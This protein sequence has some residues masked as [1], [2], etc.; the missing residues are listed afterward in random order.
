MTSERNVLDYAYVV[1]KW[2]RM[3]ILSVLV[4]GVA[5]VGIS[6]LLPKEWTADTTLLPPEQDGAQLGLAS[7]L[8]SKAPP[9]LGMFLGQSD[10][11][12]RL[13]TIL[14][15]RRVL[16][17]VVDQ[18]DLV[19]EFGAPNRAIAIEYLDER[20]RR[21][22]DEDG[23]LHIQ[24]TALH[25][26][27]AADLANAL[28]G[29]LDAV[30]RHYKSMQAQ[31]LR[32]FLEDR[33]RVVREEL[34]HAGE[35]LRVFQQTHGVV[36]MQ[37]QTAASVEVITAVA[38]ELALRQVE[39]DMQ[40]HLL[41]PGHEQ[42]ERAELQVAALRR[43]VRRLV[44]EA[45][46]VVAD[47]P[48]APGIGTGPMLMELPAL[49]QQYARLVLELEVKEAVVGYLGTRL[50]EMR[51]KEA[52]NTPTILVLDP[53]VPPAFRS[54]PH[55]KAIVAGAAGVSLVVSVL[56]AFGLESLSRIRTENAGRIAAI[57][58]LLAR[59]DARD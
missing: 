19:R 32:E 31:M 54:A 38:Q 18:L 9:N 34:D 5:A 28:A 40:E 29:E 41:G 3:I 11:S 59:S 33:I 27:L 24:V 43:Q 14:G 6:F 16:G 17:A 50:E 26:Q 2:R 21:E 57:R 25:P 42:L 4:V 23:G 52:K 51:Y 8:S 47:S 30:N 53:A 10:S 22:L 45:E 13:L 36:D 1:I 37:A 58:D 48:T 7:M 56:L 15:S 35:R 12:E 49:S 55:R 46:Q 20:M 44:G 39:L